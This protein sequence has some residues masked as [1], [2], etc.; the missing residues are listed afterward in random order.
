MRYYV[1]HLFSNYILVHLGVL[2]VYLESLQR[3][4]SGAP[5]GAWHTS[6]GQAERRPGL[7]IQTNLLSFFQIRVGALQTRQ[8]EFEKRKV[9][10]VRRSYPGR[11]AFIRL[12]RGKR[13]LALGY[14][15]APRGAPAFAALRRGEPAF[16]T[17]GYGEQT[18]GHKN[19]GRLRGFVRTFGWLLFRPC[20]ARTFVGHGHPGLRA[21]RFT[22]GCHIAGLRP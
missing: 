22:P 12:R 13:R 1:Y 8:P 16:A 3:R 7:R 21:A 10:V 14:Y 4:A 17:R 11:P 5:T 19:D 2:A 18:G 15:H 6:P 20:R 9:W